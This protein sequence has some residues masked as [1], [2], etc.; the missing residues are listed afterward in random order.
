MKFT[1]I[2]FLSLMG[3][4][5]QA[6]I[7]PT[8]D[9]W[10]CER[11][12]VQ[13][14]SALELKTVGTW[15]RNSHQSQLPVYSIPTP[16]IAEWVIIEKTFDGNENLY[17]TSASKKTKYSFKTT[18]ACAPVVSISPIE[19]TKRGLASLEWFDDKNL[20][21]LLK[22][23]P[24]SILFIWSPHMSLS[25]K[26]VKEL[27]TAATELGLPITYVMDPLADQALAKSLALKNNLGPGALRRID[28]FDLSMRNAQIHF[29]TL[30]VFRDGKICEGIQRG[31][32]ESFKF[33]AIITELFGACK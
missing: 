6:G 30:V 9:K 19:K 11:G 31:Y 7:F 23:K 10:K 33:R 28:S 3:L 17:V 27:T 25:L 32:R 18:S 20:E 1:V 26:S 2:L 16:R 29:P 14:L 15:R 21:N 4:G 22:E 24:N 13:T 12:M 5:A 8:V